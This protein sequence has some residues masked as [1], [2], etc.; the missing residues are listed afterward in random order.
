QI[1][2]HRIIEG[3]PPG[4]V[5]RAWINRTDPGLADRGRWGP[6]VRADGT[7]GEGKPSQDR[8]QPPATWF[9]ERHDGD[10]AANRRDAWRASTTFTATMMGTAATNISATAIKAV[11][12]AMTVPC[13]PRVRAIKAR[14]ADAAVPGSMPRP[15]SNAEYSPMRSVSAC[16]P[17]VSTAPSMVRL[18][19][20]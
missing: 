20:A 14:A 13:P 8:E 17:G 1:A 10:P 9:G 12:K 15:T 4:R 2:E 18:I 19:A 5:H 6:V 3:S 16:D 11:L 7:T